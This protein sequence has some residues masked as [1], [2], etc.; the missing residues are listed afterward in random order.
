VAG[1]VG[2][3]ISETF[4][5]SS[6]HID[7][8][9]FNKMFAL[10]AEFGLG[11]QYVNIIKDL[12]KD[13]LRG[14]HYFPQDIAKKY[15]VTLENFFDPKYQSNAISALDEL[16]HL[17]QNKLDKAMEYTLYISTKEISFR[18]FCLWPL[19]FA[20][21][22]LKAVSNNKALLLQGKNIKITRFQV[23]F[24]IIITS[25]FSRSNFLLKLLYKY[26]SI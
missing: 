8:S 18:L 13:Y 1:V 12:H 7:K 25:I 16:I 22:T 21:R 17:A 24:I 15:N 26:F 11:L 14:W 5:T 20:L 4:F 6:K 2:E 23:K 9:T 10:S 3:M 19:F